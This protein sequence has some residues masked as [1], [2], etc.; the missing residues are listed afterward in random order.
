M[1]IKLRK[2]LLA[3]IP[4][5]HVSLIIAPIF[6]YVDLHIWQEELIPAYLKGL[7]IIVPTALSRLLILNCRR[8]FVYLPLGIILAALWFAINPILG[9]VVLF[10]VLIRLA[11]RF[12]SGNRTVFD[13]PH[14]AGLAAFAAAYILGLAGELPQLQFIALASAVLY[15]TLTLLFISL[16]RLENYIEL[17]REMADFP[18]RRVDSTTMKTV[19]GLV[20]VLA[21]LGLAILAAGFESYTI[22][23]FT[24]PG[25]EMEEE[26]I[27]SSDGYSG[28]DKM[29]INMPGFKG[30]VLNINWK[31]IG[32]FIIVFVA[33]VMIIS[34]VIILRR[35]AGAFGETQFIREDKDIIENIKD[36]EEDIAPEKRKRELIPDMSANAFVRRKYR[37]AVR[38]GGYS[39]EKWQSPAEIES[40]AGINDE[41]LHSLYEKARYSKAG[42][43]TEDKKL[44]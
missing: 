12:R 29:N 31:L 7:S 2:A 22:P 21:V 1:K 33:A 39:P 3:L 9:I 5:L 16:R 44:L 37:K 34:A 8:M 35:L 18:A 40:G 14:Y 30:H 20:L 26:M 42:C 19:L 32:R 25:D 13:G 17:N 6:A 4:W 24:N 15:G 28:G 23:E 11:G 36:K 10:I 41:V 38:A 27:T 43:S